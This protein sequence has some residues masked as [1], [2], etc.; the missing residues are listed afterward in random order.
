MSTGPRNG[1][2]PAPEQAVTVSVDSQVGPPRGPGRSLPVGTF[3]VALGTFLLT[4]AVLLP[5][6]VHERVAVLPAETRF[7]MRLVDEEAAYLD[8]STWSWIEETEIERTTQ[9]GGSAHGSDWS[10]WEMSVDTSVSERMIDHW[11]R[12]VIV[13]RTTGRAVNCCGEHVDGDH[14]VRQA[15]LVLHFPPGSDEDSYL[16]YDAEVRSA[17]DLEFEEEDEV[18][19]VSVRRYSQEIEDT[20]VP[21]S[22]REVP[23]NLFTSGVSGTVTATR[24]LE[25]TRTLWVEP[26]SGMVVNMEE[27]R[28]ETLR[29]QNGGGSVPLLEADL[30]LVDQQVS[31]YAEQARTRSVLLRTLESWAPWTLGPLGALM[32]LTGVFRARRYG[33]QETPE[34]GNTSDGD[35]V[36]VPKDTEDPTKDEQ[37]L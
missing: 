30:A 4:V 35:K 20:Q 27:S 34:E 21:D 2:A 37:P 24:W 16:H 19:G 33:G 31:G 1:T 13:D 18:A 10:A 7:D 17:P 36:Q 6:Y 3:L 5:L 15:G 26:V 11:S 9:V 8:S 14:A 22:A 28:T 32:V 23:A 25:A 29:P 12:R